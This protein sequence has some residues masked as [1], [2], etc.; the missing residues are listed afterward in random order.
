MAVDR[1][2]NSK[3]SRVSLAK[4]A[5]RTG[6]FGSGSSDLDPMAQGGSVL[7]L[8]AGVLCGRRRRR[9]T[10]GVWFRGGGLAGDAQTGAPG[11]NP[12]AQS[13]ALLGGA[14]RRGG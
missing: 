4:G 10:A 8:V 11:V 2:L 1:G 9:N 5:G 7:D 3:K 12:V 14:A 13:S 6:I